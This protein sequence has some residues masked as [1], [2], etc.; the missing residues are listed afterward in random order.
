M[1]DLKNLLTEE[2]TDKLIEIIINPNMPTSSKVIKNRLKQAGIIQQSAKARKATDDI[3]KRI[4][5]SDF[6][7]H[8]SRRT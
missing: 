2:S 3:L 4:N 6:P 7:I 8:G 5:E 1:K